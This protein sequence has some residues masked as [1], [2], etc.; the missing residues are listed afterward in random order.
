VK[1]GGSL[2][3]ILNRSALRVGAFL[4]FLATSFLLTA[5]IYGAVLASQEMNQPSPLTIPLIGSWLAVTP[6]LLGF[7][8]GL[9]ISA[10]SYPLWRCV[11]AAATP[12]AIG[13]LIAVPI[14]NMSPRDRG[15][16]AANV[17]MVLILVISFITPRLIRIRTSQ[18]S[19]GDA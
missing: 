2:R 9:L 13:A 6:A 1:V 3:N 4:T 18:R 5:I 19:A 7:G 17:A 12:I 11:V 10:G 8:A 14:G 16:W 15:E